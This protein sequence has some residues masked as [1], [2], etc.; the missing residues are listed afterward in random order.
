MYDTSPGNSDHLLQPI[1]D[2]YALIQDLRN[3]EQDPFCR[4]K[5]PSP[6]AKAN[7]LEC[8]F[9]V[10]PV[11]STDPKRFSLAEGYIDGNC[12]VCFEDFTPGY[13]FVKLHC[14]HLFHYTC[15]RD[16][17]DQHGVYTTKCPSCRAGEWALHEI[18][19][20]TPE[21]LDVWD[22]AE[23]LE[24]LDPLYRD[25]PSQPRDPPG[26]HSLYNERENEALVLS[27]YW[28]DPDVSGQ[29]PGQPRSVAIEMAQVRERR[30]QKNAARRAMVPSDIGIRGLAPPST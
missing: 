7:I 28:D 29:P 10:H 11:A 12:V 17:W 16:T 18:A 25:A 26:P 22:V 27:E 8:L 13:V 5:E 9:P 20:I 6:S 4:Y 19:G 15:I 21:V 14:N 24:G 2:F 23:V 3:G 30:R 1:N